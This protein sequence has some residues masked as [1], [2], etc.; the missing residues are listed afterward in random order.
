MSNNIVFKTSLMRGTKGE[1]GDV[2]I[3]DSIPTDG[4]IAYEGNDI[5]EGYVETSAPSVI[6]DIY[7]EIE[8]ANARIDNI[9]ALPDGSTTADAELIDIRVGADGTVYPSAG[10]AVRDQFNAIAVFNEIGKNKFNKE[11]ATEGYYLEYNTGIK[12]RASDWCYSDYIIVAPN[13]S[14]VF[15]PA[16]NNFHICFYDSNKNYLSGQLGTHITTPQNCAY[17]IVS[18]T[19]NKINTAML[20]EGTTATSYEPYIKKSYIKDSALPTELNT[21]LTNLDNSIENKLDKEIGKNICNAYDAD[22]VRDGVYVAYDNGYIRANATFSAIQFPIEG[23]RKVSSNNTGAH[24]IFT[25]EYNDIINT[26]VNTKLKGYI[27]G[28]T[29]KMTGYDVPATAKYCIISVQTNNKSTLQVEYGNTQTSYEPYI[30]G[31]D[32]QKV[33][34]LKQTNYTYYN[35]KADGSGDFENLR[36]CLESITNSS[37]SNQYIV[38]IYAG[39][40]DI[41]SLYESYTGSGLFVPNYVKLKGIGDKHNVILK[42]ELQTQSTSFSLL[43]FRNVCELENLT[44]YSK[45]CR[46]TIHDDFQSGADT[47]AYRLIKNCIFK[48]ENTAYGSVYGSGLKGNS[49]WEFI[50]CEFDATKAASNGTAGNA[51]SNHNNVNVSTPSYISFRNCRLINDNTDWNALR[52]LSMTNGSENGTVTVTIEGCRIDGIT[53]AENDAQEYGAGI[54]YWLNG[55]GNVINPPQIVIR[56]TDDKDYSG[57]IDL[58]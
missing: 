57:N 58:I 14:Y 51:F 22:N 20:E 19:I 54:N 21:H 52:L 34:G 12:R 43:N 25:T 6:G 49:N 46:Y 9:I 50:N 4:V 31:L 39:E 55:F 41:A 53:L 37:E 23:G 42:A 16:N 32:A 26:P 7:N 3:S 40:Y 15:T 29:G 17:L 2:G 33:I 27:T 44:L 18:F 36:A 11:T 24:I 30:V 8:E 1:R 35:I 5:P 10:D 56:N 45:N 47:K 28:T 38:N 48:A 13:S